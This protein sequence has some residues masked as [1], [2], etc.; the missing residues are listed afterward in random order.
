M[1]KDMPFFTDSLCRC[2]LLFPW[3]RALLRD[4]T[5]VRATAARENDGRNNQDVNE[6][7]NHST[8]D[9]RGERL[10]HFRALVVTPHI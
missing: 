4:S 2:C 5:G 3:Q 6:A 1:T 8:N 9:G 7:G 10:H